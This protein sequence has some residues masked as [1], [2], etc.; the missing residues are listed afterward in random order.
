[1]VHRMVLSRRFRFR[2]LVRLAGP[3]ILSAIVLVSGIG[4]VR[5]ADAWQTVTFG[6][7]S[8]QAPSA[9]PVHDLAADPTRCVRF[10]RSAVYLGTQ[11]PEARC[12]AHAVGRA[13]AV[14]VERIDPNAAAASLGPE[15]ETASGLRY[16]PVLGTAT[17]RIVEAEFASM[18]VRV[19]LPYTADPAAAQRILDSFARAS[20]PTALPAAPAPGS[21]VV[22]ARRDTSSTASLQT[23][24]G[25]WYEGL[26]VDTCDAPSE[27][28]MQA[29]LASPYRG[30]GIYIGGL[31]RACDQQ[32]NLTPAWVAD[33]EAM[34]WNL[35]PTYVGL[36]APC[37]MGQ[38][39]VTIDPLHAANQGKAEADDAAAQVAALG[40]GQGAPVYFDMEGYDAND[41]AC[42]DTVATFLS[43]WVGEMHVKH[44]AAGVYGGAASTIKQL[45]EHYGDGSLHRPDDVWI[46]HWD[47]RQDVFGDPYVPDTMWPHHQRLHQYQG[48]HLETWGGVQINVDNDICDGQ[49]VGLRRNIAFAGHGTGPREI[50]VNG[51][52]G[53]G[54]RQLTRNS[55]DDYT[56]A[57]SPDGTRIAYSSNQGG[58]YNVWVMNADGSGKKQLT[59]NPKFDGYP[60]WSPDG[61]KLVFQSTRTGHGNLW[62]I[63]AD[64]TGISQLTTT[65]T[66]NDVRPSWSPDGNTIAFGSNRSGNDDVWIVGTNR[67][68]LKR[69]TWRPQADQDPSWSPNGK[70]IAFG[71]DR[72]GNFE[73]FTITPQGTAATQVSSSPAS[74]ASPSWSVDSKRIAFISTR[75]GT[76][77]VW[78]MDADGAN[79][80]KVTSSGPKNEMPSWAR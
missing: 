6:P 79:A 5:A 61:S 56:P 72:T 62:F 54:A 17:V 35:I 60:S 75:S 22:G 57:V 12:P 29:W 74:D 73:I 63:N 33:V 9:W 30:I 67:T 15:R 66:A 25:A 59:F 71:S 39:L 14:L 70:L 8:F 32:P 77:Q 45:A 23:Y 49:L 76:T 1:M 65:T 28:A 80:I 50:F 78:I 2:G 13:D 53:I 38:G 18:G 10:D 69:L 51:A 36:Q 3:A 64:G 34:G 16:R 4:P 31:N 40:L 47:G 52:D 43:A 48:Q 21:A 55:V 27:S 44:L 58:N 20:S 68:G 11:G 46:A 7:V 37:V 19:I 24:G 42:A 41:Q 26:G